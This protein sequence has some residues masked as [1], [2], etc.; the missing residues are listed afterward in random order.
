MLDPQDG[1]RLPVIMIST[2]AAVSVVTVA[3]CVAIRPTIIRSTI[4]VGVGRIVNLL[5]IARII[6]VVAFATVAVAVSIIIPVSVGLRIA[7]SAVA[8]RNR[9]ALGF[10]CRHRHESQGR[11][12]ESKRE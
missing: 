12:T 8:E 4:S 9:E 7:V 2:V 1:R 3:I 10:R 5:G 11:H 6:G